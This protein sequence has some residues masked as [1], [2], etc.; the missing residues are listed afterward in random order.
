MSLLAISFSKEKA[1]DTISGLLLLFVAFFT[2][3]GGW[4]SKKNQ[5]PAA[6]G[7]LTGPR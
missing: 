2:A 5:L 3:R 7:R 6:K 1:A 4:L